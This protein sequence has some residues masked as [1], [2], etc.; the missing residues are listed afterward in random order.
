[1]IG[2]LDGQDLCLVVDALNG[3][4]VDAH[5]GL[6]QRQMLRIELEDSIR[7]SGLDERWNV[8][9]AALLAKI[10]D[11]EDS[12]VRRL[13]EGARRFWDAV[14]RGE[15]GD[16]STTELVERA[17]GQ[18]WL[19]ESAKLSVRE[20]LDLLGQTR[21]HFKSKLVGRARE[22]LEQLLT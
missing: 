3:I 2:T 16:A 15:G 13:L 1:M 22:L 5:P 19:N 6:D 17:F 12:Q 10:D 11:L 7:L 20:A 4:L 18:P 14:G 21:D 8:D 9:A